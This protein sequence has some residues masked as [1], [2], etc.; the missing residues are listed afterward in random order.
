MSPI[1]I[2]NLEHQTV[3]YIANILPKHNVS[4]HQTNMSFCFYLAYQAWSY[5]T[6]GSGR[7]LV[8][9]QIIMLTL[10]KCN[11]LQHL[12]LH[13]GAENGPMFSAQPS[14]LIIQAPLIPAWGQVR[15]QPDLLVATTNGIS[16]L[17]TIQIGCCYGLKKKMLE[18]R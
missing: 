2:I 9:N 4:P 13:N 5:V 8:Y 3:A 16:Y 14:P 6:L 12:L 1:S 17:T 15:T 7:H 11:D 10:C 18:L